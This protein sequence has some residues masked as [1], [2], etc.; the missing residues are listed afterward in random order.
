M[1]YIIVYLI[2][3]ILSYLL[4]KYITKK[5]YSLWTIGDRNSAIMISLFSY[6]AFFV[7]LSI[8]GEI[9]FNFK[10]ETPAKW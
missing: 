6:I 1:I 3:C 8:D 2:G 4:S 7:I 9:I 5:Q 10:D